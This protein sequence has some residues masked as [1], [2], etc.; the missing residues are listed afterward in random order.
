[1]ARFPEESV[2]NPRQF[3]LRGAR[4]RMVLLASTQPHS[5]S[6][7]AAFD[8]YGEFQQATIPLSSRSIQTDMASPGSTMSVCSVSVQP[9]LA[10][11]RCLGSLTSSPRQ[12][13]EVTPPRRKYLTA[14]ISTANAV[15]SIPI[16][17]SVKKRE[18][19]FT[20]SS[21]E[22]LNTNVK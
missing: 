21:Y 12:Q 2:R 5:Q 16:N 14:L 18:L 7:A 4:R 17:L 8:S 19:R 9:D 22:A 13:G 20:S 15:G 6:L 3:P 1:M 10:G 11:C